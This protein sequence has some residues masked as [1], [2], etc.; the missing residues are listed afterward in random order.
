MVSIT[1][2]RYYN[3]KYE[4]IKD[5]ILKKFENKL[6]NEGKNSK[7]Y[8]CNKELYDNNICLVFEWQSRWEKRTQK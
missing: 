3:T 2:F 8:Y 7:Y 6:L 4:I 5:S 1:E